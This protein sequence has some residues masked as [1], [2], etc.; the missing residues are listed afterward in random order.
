VSQEYWQ[1]DLDDRTENELLSASDRKRL[2]RAKQ[3]FPEAIVVKAS[4]FP[5]KESSN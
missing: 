3:L 5:A 4:F 2:E 1:N